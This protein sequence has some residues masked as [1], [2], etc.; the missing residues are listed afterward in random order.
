MLS[1]LPVRWEAAK[2][3]GKEEREGKAGMLLMLNKNTLRR[4]LHELFGLLGPKLL[5]KV[6]KPQQRK[7]MGNGAGDDGERG[8]QGVRV[9]RQAA[10][11]IN[12]LAV[13]VMELEKR[14]QKIWKHPARRQQRG[15]NKDRKRGAVR[16]GVKLMK[17]YKLDW[18]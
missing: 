11:N 5:A 1:A 15:K 18:P 2:E 3:D 12:K 13:F 9:M 17:K 14:L 4:S 6:P 7:H 8:L 10:G 16:Q